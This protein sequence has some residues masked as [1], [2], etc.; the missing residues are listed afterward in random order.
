MILPVV[1]GLKQA[2]YVSA[3]WILLGLFL[4][5]ILIYDLGIGFV[6]TVILWLLPILL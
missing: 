1:S 3:L 6:Y 5:I 2:A 4:V